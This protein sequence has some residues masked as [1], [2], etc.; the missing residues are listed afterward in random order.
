MS[1]EIILSSE[2]DDVFKSI[3]DEYTS[4]VALG[5][6]KVT[7]SEYF[8]ALYSK[9]VLFTDDTDTILFAN[10]TFLRLQSVA[11]SDIQSKR[12]QDVIIL[13]S[14]IE[15]AEDA[16]H[17]FPLFNAQLIN[18]KNEADRIIISKRL[19]TNSEGIYMYVLERII[20]KNVVAEV[21]KSKFDVIEDELLKRTQPLKLLN[22]QLSSEINQK[23]LAEEAARKSEKRFKALF[24]NSPEAVFVEDF[25]G[26]IIDLNDAA[27]N[28]HGYS[29]DEMINKNVSVF[30]KLY[31]NNEFEERQKKIIS[32]ELRAFDSEVIHSSGKIIPIGVKV[33]L[34]DYNDETRVLLHA[35][36]ISQRLKHQKELERINHVLELK[37]KERTK[38][39]EMLNVNLQ[40]EIS[41]RITAQQSTKSQADFFQLVIDLNPNMVFVK[42]KHGKI[43]LA[44]DTFAKFY[45]T[46]KE[47]LVGKNQ[48]GFSD[49]QANLDEFTRQ[50]EMVLNNPFNSFN[51]FSEIIN[52]SG[53]YSYFIITKQAVKFL[54]NEDLSILGVVTDV[55]RYKKIEIEIQ[56]KNKELERSN[57][58]L[59]RFASIASHDMQSPLKTIISFLQVIEQ[60]YGDKIDDDGKEFINYC[61][62]AS[63]R[64]R[65]LIIDLLNYSRLNAEPR[66]FQET[67]LNELLFI[68]KRNLEINISSKNAEITSEMLPTIIGEPYMLSQV[69]QNIID[70]SLKF[71]NH[72]TPQIKIAYAELT[73]SWLI[74]ISDNGIGIK[75]EFKEKIFKIFQRLNADNE[76]SGTGIGLAICNKVIEHHKGRI[77]VESEFGKGT[78]FHF[79]IS[80][81]LKN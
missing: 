73:D 61:I 42:D 41:Y 29:R 52:N 22:E 51:F 68:V 3:H 28:L 59:N 44:N 9:P 75:E 33:G 58:E 11:S 81:K 72:Q 25:F 23:K 4:L 24:Y 32:G 7:L 5:I 80:K 34:I 46:T 30:T 55:S 79:T 16:L 10:K 2:D 38:D 15:P 62:T 64:M 26:N 6:D 53:E 65:Q 21:L 69:F 57:E 20:C 50:D 77:W 37:V 47:N 19:L 76:Y 39:L 66:P 14:E 43:I 70:N 1:E 54:D 78:T 48:S 8:N 35:R 49:S 36:D 56:E 40:K 71:T 67:N 13:S 60:R 18:G 74:S 31:H 12:F 45:N 63:S 17:K 27:C